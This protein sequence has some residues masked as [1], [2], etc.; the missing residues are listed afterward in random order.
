MQTA[1]IGY[2]AGANGPGG[3]GATGGDGG[4]YSSTGGGGGSGYQDGSVTVID[5]MQGGSTGDAKVVLRLPGT[6]T[7]T[8]LGGGNS[9][10]DLVRDAQGRIL[11]FSSTGISDPRNLN[12]SSVVEPGSNSC[13]NDETWRY[14]LD[15]ARDGTKDYRLTGCAPNG[16]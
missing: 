15:L 8:K 6:A 13:I 11:I 16:N 2:Q 1:G 14:I 5:T 4:Y 7:V 3:N 10:A 12:K 9:F